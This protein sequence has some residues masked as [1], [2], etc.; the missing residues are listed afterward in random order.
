MQRQRDGET[1]GLRER[2]MCRNRDGETD[3]EKR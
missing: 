3:R 2:E 1:D